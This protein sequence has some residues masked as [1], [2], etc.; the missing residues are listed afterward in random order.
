MKKIPNLF[1]RDW[2]TGLVTPVF[3]HGMERMLQNTFVF[4]RRKWDGAC[5]AVF[6]GVFWKRRTVRPRKKEPINFVPVD[7][8]P[9]T[10]KQFGWMPVDDRDRWY[11][12]AYEAGDIWCPFPDGTYEL[13]GPKV[14]GGAEGLTSHVLVCHQ[15]TEIIPIPV[16]QRTFE[17]IRDLLAPLDI[18]GLVFYAVGSEPLAKIKK[19]DYGMERRSSTL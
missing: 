14:Q 9:Q 13:C 2:D 5:C 18:E 11:I 8:D 3:N 1:V 7:F 16:E 19:S 10:G 15:R 12:E 4:A 6:D 17:G